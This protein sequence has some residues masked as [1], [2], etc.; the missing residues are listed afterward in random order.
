MEVCKYALAQYSIAEQ[1][2][3]PEL[4]G[5]GW[6]HGI[7]CCKLERAEWIRVDRILEISYCA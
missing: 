2:R 6:R 4:A 5:A 3:V 1:S 7:N